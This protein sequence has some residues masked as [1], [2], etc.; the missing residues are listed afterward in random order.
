[1]LPQTKDNI[2]KLKEAGFERSNFSVRTPCNSKG[3]YEKT[4]ITLNT[5]AEKKVPEKAEELKEKGYRVFVVEKE[6]KEN[7]GFVKIPK[8]NQN[9]E[10]VDWNEFVGE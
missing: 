6:D 1:M 7:Y 9:P 8:Y 4:R 5:E 2:E 10:V 3:E